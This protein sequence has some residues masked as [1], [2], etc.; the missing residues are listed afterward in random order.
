MPNVELR[1]A[2]HDDLLEIATLLN[3]MHEEIGAFDLAPQKMRDH[4]GEILTEGKC[5][6]A[7][8]EGEIVGSIGLQGSEPWYSTTKII[9]DSWIFVSP[10]VQKRLSVFRAMVKE[11]QE[12]AKTVHMPLVLA[13][14]SEKDNN[15]KN[16]LFAR[17]G[18]QIMRGF[19]F[20]DVG[21]EFRVH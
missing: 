4:I 8:A 12:Y 7:E 9:V 11:V 14:Y 5:L 3:E 13:L 15:R 18:D 17:Y 16:R 21:G 2:T 6:V 10:R 19:Q 1:W 20:R